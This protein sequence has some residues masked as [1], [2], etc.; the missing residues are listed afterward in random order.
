MHQT[1]R[2]NRMFGDLVYVRKHKL[3]MACLL[4]SLTIKFHQS[5][6]K[7]TDVMFD[8]SV[9]ALT[10]SFNLRSSCSGTNY[11][12]FPSSVSKC[13]KYFHSSSREHT[14]RPNSLLRL[15]R[16]FPALLSS[17][18]GKHKSQGFRVISLLAPDD[19]ST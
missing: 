6:S 1:L 15:A 13:S 3:S 16:Q 4:P 7:A 17:A 18:K 10:V 19:D 8:L 5:K 9:H 12:P 11:I 14:Q 2:K